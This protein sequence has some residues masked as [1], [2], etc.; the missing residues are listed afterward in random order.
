MPPE[1]TRRERLTAYAE[2]L[3][4]RF[5]RGILAT[6][7]DKPLWVVW[8]PEQDA[9]GNMH[10]RPYTPKNY[11]ASTYKP[12][13]W[14]SLDTVLEALATGNY[15]GIGIMLPAPFVLID[16]DARAKAPIVDIEARK[17]VSPLALQ[18]VEQVPSYAELSPNNGLHIITEGRP[19]RGNCK[20]EQLEMYTNWFSTVTTKHIPGTPLDVTA[21]Q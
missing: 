6:M 10:K 8:K 9:Q 7:Q 21:Q 19:K 12:H 18:L 13:Q 16:K 15:A 5:R 3:H 2:L 17:V 1:Q 20:T 14:S 11:P 4:Q